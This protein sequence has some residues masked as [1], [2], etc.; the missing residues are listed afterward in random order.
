MDQ[1]N[2]LLS[3]ICRHN[4]PYPLLP[5]QQ[6]AAASIYAFLA[7]VEYASQGILVARD[8]FNM[9]GITIEELDCRNIHRVV[10]C[11]V[12]TSGSVCYTVSRTVPN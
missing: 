7:I 5:S 8:A 12:H 11:T 2:A 6:V 1:G 10:T 4:P 9:F 3:P